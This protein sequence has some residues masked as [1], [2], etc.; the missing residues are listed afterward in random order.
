[1]DES[2]P[3]LHSFSIK[4]LI[5]PIELHINMNEAHT[6]EMQIRQQRNTYL[7]ST[8]KGWKT[9]AFSPRTM[10]APLIHPA[11]KLLLLVEAAPETAAI[12]GEDRCGEL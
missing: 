2:P 8:F 4:A 12:A 3:K 10:G 1:M 6:Y 7:R 9:K 11:P 5:S